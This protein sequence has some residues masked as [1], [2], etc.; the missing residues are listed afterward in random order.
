MKTRRRYWWLAVLFI[1][2]LSCAIARWKGQF[3]WIDDGGGGAWLALLGVLL[4]A[5]IYAP[6]GASLLDLRWG[7][8]LMQLPYLIPGPRALFWIGSTLAVLLNVQLFV[9]MPICWGLYRKYGCEFPG[10]TEFIFSFPVWALIMFGAVTLGLNF[11]R[12]VWIRLPACVVLLVV[13]VFVALALY[14]PFLAS[15]GSPLSPRM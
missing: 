13:D 8:I 9:L 14:A 2:A 5:N 4:L 11:I 3:L 7:E 6:P 12:K 15:L 10:A 1:A